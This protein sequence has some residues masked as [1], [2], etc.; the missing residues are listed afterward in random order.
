MTG[1]CGQIV[2]PRTEFGDHL[3]LLRQLGAQ[4]LQLGGEFGDPR[5]AAVTPAGGGVP[6][7]SRLAVIGPHE[8]VRQDCPAE[9]ACDGNRSGAGDQLCLHGPSLFKPITRSAPE[10][11][12]IRQA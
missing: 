7:G 3:V 6:R 9:Q 11:G 12:T 1:R 10:P 5:R 2:E 8:M 4:R